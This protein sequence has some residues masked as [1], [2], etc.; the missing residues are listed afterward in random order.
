MDEQF[1]SGERDD[2]STTSSA[3][4]TSDPFPG[5]RLPI[6]DTVAEVIKNI[7]ARSPSSDNLPTD[8]SDTTESEVEKQGMDI[9]L[10]AIRI[11]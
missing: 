1:I 4:N 7:S 5:V 9:H 6:V 10:T 2:V 8:M 3:L 11:F